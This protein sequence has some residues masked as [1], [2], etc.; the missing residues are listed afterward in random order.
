M[1]AKIIPI[2]CVATCL[3]FF[4][5]SCED[6]TYREYEGNAP[7]YI[8]YDELRNPVSV[9]NESAL[10]DPGKIYFKDNYIFIIE[11]LKGIHVFDNTNPSSPVKMKFV[12]I[13][14]IVDM[15]ISGNALYADSFVDMVVIDVQDINNI[16]EIGRLKDILPYTVPPTGNNLPTGYI[17]QEKGLVTGWEQRTI[18]ERVY[19]DPQVYPFYR[20]GA[21]AEDFAKVTNS[22]TGGV[23]SSG[24]GIGGSMARIGI[25]DKTLYL[26]DESTL[27]I[28][29]ISVK[30]SPGLIVSMNA[31]WGIE[32]MFLTEKNMFLGTTT[33]MLIYDISNP[34]IPVRISSYNHLRSCD[35]VIVDDTL[36]YV[37][38]RTGTNCG[39]SIN[40]LDVVNIKNLQ[41]PKIVWSYPMVNPHGLGKDGDLLFIC[42]GASGLKI[43]DASDP[44]TITS[45]LLFSYPYIQAY[46]VIPIGGVLV[47]IGDNGLYQYSYTDIKNISLLST[48]PVVKID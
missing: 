34:Q 41:S 27:R 28:F 32:T 29:D 38:L 13:P 26:L 25:K 15:A 22:Y 14:G 33:G 47:M 6:T 40:S 46:D 10:E 21:M 31:G 30:S 5:T 42:D 17:D 16:K 20:T 39:G 24:V 2:I 43:Y 48:I 36:A 3:S 45:H 11:E 44:K 4:F 7:V 9:T 12:K 37:T 23:S 18:R 8:T 35:P 1:K 19:K